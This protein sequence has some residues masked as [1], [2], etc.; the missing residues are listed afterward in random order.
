MTQQVLET[1]DSF[2]IV[3]QGHV[4]AWD[5]PRRDIA[6]T[7]EALISLKEIEPHLIDLIEVFQSV[8]YPLEV[9]MTYKVLE[10]Q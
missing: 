6:S 10:I 9:R 4:I 2:L 7:I 8:S 5:V 1:H 3:F